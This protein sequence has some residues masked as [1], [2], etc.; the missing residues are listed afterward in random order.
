MENQ[1][2][3]AVLKEGNKQSI[4][5]KAKYLNGDKAWLTMDTLHLEDPYLLINHTYQNQL[6]LEPGF[7]WIQDYLMTDN[8]LE[9]ITN[10]Y[11]TTRLEKTYMF[12]VEVP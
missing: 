4:F 12:G 6:Q 3:Y 10:A 7:E 5:F 1:E 9:V 2:D 8:E 11:G